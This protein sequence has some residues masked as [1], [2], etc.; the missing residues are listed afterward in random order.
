MIAYNKSDLENNLLSQE[1]KL[2]LKT[3]YLNDSDSYESVDWSKVIEVNSNTYRVRH[4]FRAKN[5]YG[6]L[7][8]ENKIF[9]LDSLGN[10][11]DMLDVN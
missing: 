4:K 11:T 9:S 8:I 1:A 3:K 5:E 6:A 7:V 2:F 10:V